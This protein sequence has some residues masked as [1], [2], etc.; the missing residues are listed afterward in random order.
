LAWATYDWASNSFPTIIQTFVFASYFAGQVAATENAGTTW[1]G[2]ALGIAGLIVA[3]AA[4]V[5]GALVDQLGRRKRWIAAFTWLAVVAAALMWFIRPSPA[6]V[7]PA[8]L[9]VGIGTIGS[10]LA[11]LF[12][13]AMLP[14]LASADQMGKWS[15]WGWGAGYAGG[16]ACLGLALFGFV[17]PEGAWLGLNAAQD[18]HVRAT[19]PLTAAWLFVFSLPLLILT[20]DTGRTDK[21]LRR[22]VPDAFD[23]L[24]KS[25]REVHRYKHI[26]RFLIARLFYVDGLATMFAFGG[27]YARGTF[28][29][30][31]K[32]ILA[33]GIGLN[34]AA[35]VGALCF[36]W[37]DDWIGGK[38]TV[39]IA[40]AGLILAGTA[41]LLVQ[42]KLQFWV[43]AL[44]LG[45]FVGP[46]QSGSRSY[47]ARVAP[48]ELHNQVF[49]LY[50]FSGKA[51]AFVGPLL[52]AGLTWLS[53]SQRVGMSV[54]V[55]LLLTGMTLLLTVP[56][57]EEIPP[58]VPEDA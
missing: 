8:L 20:P 29:M 54:V 7:A 25:F 10:E 4:P 23:Q 35:G 40:L 2:V 9:L 27:I 19:F 26:V 32:E 5:L 30:G 41:L 12:Y 21:T 38:R 52:V 11:F 53:Q 15:G 47:L 13:N 3:L 49:G 18:E 17:Y 42:S 51:T 57:A 22:A 55:L 33:F 56:R 16:L 36:A 31:P 44:L 45:V 6:Y 39:L 43:F 1:W 46:A 28:G 50:A 48:V 24:R 14:S 37:V 34:V 58:V